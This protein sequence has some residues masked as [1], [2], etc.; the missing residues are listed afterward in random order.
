MKSSFH[1]RQLNG[2]FDDPGLYVRLIRE[3]RALMFD[4]GFTNSLTPRDIL[5]ISDIFVSH[6]HVDHFIGFDTILRISLRKET[7]LRLYGP[8][9]FIDCV[10]GKLRSYTWNIIED[11]PLEIHVSE[12]DGPVIRKAV[13]SAANSF[14]RIN[15]GSEP[16]NGILLK[17][18]FFSVMSTVLDHQIPCL[19]FS[20][21]EDFHIN[22][23]KSRLINMNLPVGPWLGDLKKAIREK[24]TSNKFSI[25]KK[26]YAYTDVHDVARITR[27]Q[28]ISYVVDAVG[29]KDNMGKI[30]SLVRGSDVL[31]IET[32]F[33]DEDRDRARERY[34]LTA[35]EAGK[36]AREAGVRRFEALHFS[37]KYMKISERLV[38]EAEQEF[39]NQN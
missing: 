22:I 37:P 28:K 9:G 17:E 25:E 8:R 32:F 7:P 33:L 11:Y 15:R 27:G 21:E 10:E 20:L 18:S 2:P 5:K 13:F 3:G 26:V 23:D 29:S 12:V 1:I 24:R 14:K 34:H 39:K 36:I 35:K 30:I 19:A 16:F 31:Y 4:L 6:T 38:E